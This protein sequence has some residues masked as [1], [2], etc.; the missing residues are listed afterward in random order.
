[1]W[2]FIQ[3]KVVLLPR[4]ERKI[5]IKTTPD[6]IFNIVTDRLNTPKWNLTVSAISS[7]TDEKTQ[8]ETDVGAVTIVNVETEKNKSAVYHME[9]SD[10]SSIGYII[11]AKT[12]NTE[13]KIWTEFENKKLLKL[14]K[15]TADRVLVGLK[16]Y[17]EFIEEGGNPNLYEKSEILAS[18]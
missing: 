10:M 15:K 6:K 18:L 14:Y 4:I 9:K 3:N 16:K 11:T 12:D 2:I 17:A 7:I 1:M 13:V 8:L 5:G